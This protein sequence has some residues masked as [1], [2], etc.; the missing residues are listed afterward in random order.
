MF[1]S[2]AMRLP[3]RNP[4]S[5]AVSMSLLLA[6]AVARAQGASGGDHLDEVVVSATKVGQQELSKV[7]MA[8]QAFTGE[9]LTS[10]GIGDAKSLMELIPGAS[11]Q[12]EIG[13]GYKVFSF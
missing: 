10:K 13:A 9:S 8:I 1:N 2:N 5:V 3:G 4:V 11:E 7:P 6:S 12:S